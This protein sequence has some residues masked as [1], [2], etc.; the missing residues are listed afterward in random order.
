MTATPRTDDFQF[1]SLRLRAIT[2]GSGRSL[3]ILHE[4]MGYSGWMSWHSALARDYSL[5]IPLAP[6]FGCAPRIDWIASVR[7]LAG[8]YARLV[9]EQ[10]LAPIDVVGFSL[11]GW[12]AA[13][14]A[15]LDPALLRRMVLVAPLGIK[16]EQGEILDAFSLTHHAQLQAT[17]FDAATTPEFDKLYGGATT[18]EQ[19]EAIDDARA[20]S[21]RLAWQPYL[22]NPSLPHLL[23]GVGAKVPTLL[24][25]GEEDQVIPVSTME[26]YRRA[27]GKAEILRLPRCG[28]RPEIENTTAFLAAARQFLD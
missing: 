26:T 22:H 11:G 16:P 25:W 12:I 2:A 21:A 6:G 10:N 20:E 14:M 15:A 8:V 9:R 24:V 18:P 1:G 4:E 3:L 17:L 13:E 23:E 19:V 5:L 28:H 27:L 7:D